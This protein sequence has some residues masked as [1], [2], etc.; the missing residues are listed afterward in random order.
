MRLSKK[1]DGWFLVLDDGQCNF[2]PWFVAWV[3]RRGFRL[4]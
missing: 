2:V 1:R 4:P 3:L